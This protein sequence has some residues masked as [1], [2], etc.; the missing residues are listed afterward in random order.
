MSAFHNYLC[1]VY[2]E[3]TLVP[4]LG[5]FGVATGS[6]LSSSFQPLCP[7]YLSMTSIKNLTEVQRQIISIEK[8]PT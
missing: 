7:L 6:V 2:F 8:L 1:T 3:M 5:P 4:S